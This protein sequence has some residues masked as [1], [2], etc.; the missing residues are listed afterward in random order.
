[1]DMIIEV[2]ETDVGLE[3][4]VREASVDHLERLN[5]E[6]YFSLSTY[7]YERLNIPIKERKNVP[8]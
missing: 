4:T 7:W 5:C 2:T 8:N 6:E 1:M 3:L